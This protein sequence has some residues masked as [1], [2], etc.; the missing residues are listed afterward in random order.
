MSG[1]TMQGLADWN[2]ESPIS[3]SQ[4][5]AT[6]R[7]VAVVAESSDLK[8]YDRIFFPCARVRGS[9]LRSPIC[10]VRPVLADL[11]RL[12]LPAPTPSVESNVHRSHGRADEVQGAPCV[13]KRAER[14]VAPCVMP[15]V[16]ERWMDPMLVPGRGLSSAKER[17]MGPGS[18][19]LKARVSRVSAWG[20][21]VQRG[22]VQ[23]EDT[24][25]VVTPLSALDAHPILID[26]PP[27]C[28]TRSLGDR[29][30][31]RQRVSMIG[32]P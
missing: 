13:R 2:Q 25:N 14:L 20:Y 5:P 22:T 7:G 19:F 31:L 8:F 28:A 15:P 30:L 12:V 17:R 11:I 26:R 23:A 10:R 4:P 3:G 18:I 16:S 9:Q 6:N 29:R 21:R 32:P 27:W 24:L 1:N